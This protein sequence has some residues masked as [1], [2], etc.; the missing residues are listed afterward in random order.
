M[1]K[2]I[3]ISIHPEHVQNILLGLKKYEYRKVTAKQEASSML[4]YETSPT[5]KV[6]AEVKI[7]A[8]LTYPPEELWDLTHADSCIS[9]EFFDNYFKER[10][11]AHAYK[12]GKIKIF[13][14][15]KKLCEY[16]IKTA[17]Q[18]FVYL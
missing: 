14:K 5:M 8:V 10:S 18:S 9:K 15:P 12:L 17:P 16:G 3:L 11:I 1:K 7:E 2:K 4:I 13:D 6:V